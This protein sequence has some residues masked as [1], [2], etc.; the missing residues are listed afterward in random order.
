MPLPSDVDLGGEGLLLR[1]VEQGER[2]RGGARRRHA[3]APAR[4]EVA[5]RVEPGDV[6][7]PGGRD[8]R[9]LVGAARAHLDAR[10]ASGGCRHP[11]GRR[12]DRRVVV[13]DRQDEGLEDDPLGE[14]RLDDEDR[15]LGE[16]ALA[17]GVAADVAREAVV[18]EPLEGRSVDDLGIREEA[19][20]VVAE[21]EVLER[22]EDPSR[23]GDDAV[24]PAVGQPPGERLEDAPPVRLARGERGL[25]HRQLVV[26]GQQRRARGAGARRA[27]SLSLG[28]D[29]RPGRPP[30]DRAWT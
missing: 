17:L 3:V 19:Q 20:L 7:R 1:V 30:R 15:R 23:S 24:A 29:G 12:G 11:R 22:L 2:V 25:E 8:G 10:S 13:E 14:R 18:G 27:H 21:A 9:L 16:V 28:G 4:L 6:G 26:V 5:R